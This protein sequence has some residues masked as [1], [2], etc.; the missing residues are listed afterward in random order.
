MIPFFNRM[1]PGTNLQD[2]NLDWIICKVKELADSF[3]AFKTEVEQEL[4]D[5]QPSE[6]TQEQVDLLSELAN[7]IPFDMSGKKVSIIG[8]SISTFEGYVVDGYPTHY[9]GAAGTTVTTVDKTYW[10]I[11]FRA[12]G[13]TLERNAAYSGSSASDA[14]RPSFFERCSRD[15]LGEPDVIIVELGT[16][17][18]NNQ[19]D[20]GPFDYSTVY[21][22]LPE[23]KFASAYIKG[24]KALR[25]LYPN[26]NIICLALNMT[27]EYSTAIQMIAA[28]LRCNFVYCYTYLRENGSHPGAIGMSQIADTIMSSYNIQQL[29][30]GVLVGETNSIGTIHFMDRYSEQDPPAQQSNGR[31]FYW[32]DTAGDN[33]ACIF[34]QYNPGGDFKID[35]RVQHFTNHTRDALERLYFGLDANKQPYAGMTTPSIWLAALGLT[36]ITEIIANPETLPENVTGLTMQHTKSGKHHKLYLN[37]VLSGAF[38]SNFEAA[39]LPLPAMSGTMYVDV[40][41][42]NTVPTAMTAPCLTC[43]ITAQGKLLM[44]RGGPGTYHVNMDYYEA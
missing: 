31:G 4:E 5:I 35:C 9:P 22:D 41:P 19:V 27:R 42:Y 38:T 6:E 37:V 17:D 21:T 18:S 8:D 11:L 28:Q 29:N 36:T 23:N 12:T 16:N 43:G 44:L 20:V 33:V 14:S 3:T 26:A 30:N 39:T 1:F 10:D 2:L 15:I 25:A 40:M 13:A 7:N 32:H 24:I 34:S